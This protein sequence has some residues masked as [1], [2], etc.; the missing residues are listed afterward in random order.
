M[1]ASKAVAFPLQSPAIPATSNYLATAHD[2]NPQSANSSTNPAE[3]NV[4]RQAG[5][6][7]RLL[8]R[9]VCDQI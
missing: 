7:I 4:F 9:V 1:F 2:P 6:Y 8:G 3:P 5:N